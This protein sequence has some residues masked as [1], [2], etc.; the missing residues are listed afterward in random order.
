VSLRLLC[1]FV[2]IWDLKREFSFELLEFGSKVERNGTGLCLSGSR[3]DEMFLE[4]L[5]LH[6]Y[7]SELRY[8]RRTWGM[9]FGITIV[10]SSKFSEGVESNRNFIFKLVLG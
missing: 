9:A 5:H 3:L 10:E 4:P 8:H 6:L 7:F 1:V 2:L